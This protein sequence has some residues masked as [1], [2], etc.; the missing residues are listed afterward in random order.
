[1]ALCQQVMAS[2]F[3]FQF[4]VDL[5]LS[6]TQITVA[7]SMILMFSLTATFYFPKS[8]N[9][10]KTYLTQLYTITLSKGTIFAKNADISKIKGSRH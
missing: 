8:K 2:S 7:W 9:G 5:E 6:G 10:P 4:T 1:M 3:F